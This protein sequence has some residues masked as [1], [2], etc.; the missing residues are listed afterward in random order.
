MTN[1][2]NLITN[3][4]FKEEEEMVVS[5]T[6]KVSL[7]LSIFSSRD[8]A[9][10]FIGLRFNLSNINILKRRRKKIKIKYTNCKVKKKEEGNRLR[11]K[12]P[13]YLWPLA[14]SFWRS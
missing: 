1:G 3:M 2:D 10:N 14:R 4:N 6:T 9:K 5:G 12:E 8:R 7:N 11:R 13:T